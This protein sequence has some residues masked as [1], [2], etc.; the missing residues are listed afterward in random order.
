M[1]GYA[2]SV[3]VVAV[4]PARGGSKGLPGK[5][6][7]PLAGV[8]LV[9]RSIRAAMAAP[10][11]DLVVV[12]SDDPGILEIAEA[13][14]AV[15]VTRPD[16]LSGDLASSE[17]AV[18]HALD[19]VGGTPEIVVFLQCTSPFTKAEEVEALVEALDDP[20]YDAALTVIEDHS[21]IWTFA[22]DGAGKGVNHDHSLPRARRQELPPA[23]RET[24]AG[25]AMRIAPFRA[26][27][28]RFCGPVALVETHG[29]IV[30]IDTLA[31]FE[32]A[33]AIAQTLPKPD[34]GTERLAE[35][36]ALVTDFDGVHTDDAVILSQE[37][38]E[39]VRC[40]RRDGLGIEL[41]RKAGLPVLILSKEINPVVARRAEKL[42]V[43]VIHGCDDKLPVLT[44]WAKE[45]GLPLSAIAY[46]GNDV[47]DVPCMAAVGVSFA[48]ADSH[49]SAL[50]VATHVL[51]TA[52]GQGAVREVCDLLMS[53]R[54]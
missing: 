6:L 13:E 4:I 53:A 36:K 25:Y 23:F 17:S 26:V 10:S 14:G 35:I 1:T 16:E 20:V 19:V 34:A 3:R 8:P 39:H 33:E 44:G 2:S 28:R 51:A 18:I 7:K 12:S 42:K 52:G 5:N 24:G 38:V 27:G 15:A 9:A 22:E 21:F 30:D 37:G 43:P 48:P 49:P 29:P 32:M 11:V 50:R 45:Q 41:M 54:K 46:V 47:N 40:S 31:D